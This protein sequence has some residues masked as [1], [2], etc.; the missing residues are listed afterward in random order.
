[1][2]RLEK[3]VLMRDS[4][5]WFMPHSFALKLAMENLSRVKRQNGYF[6]VV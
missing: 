3:G 1:M 4:F 6:F 5:F 2:K